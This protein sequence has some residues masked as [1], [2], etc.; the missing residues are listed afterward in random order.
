[1]T[2]PVKIA[3]TMAPVETEK[4]VDGE[5]MRNNAPSAALDVLVLVLTVDVD[6]SESGR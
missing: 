6:K 4:I 5:G 3:A 2:V 1:M